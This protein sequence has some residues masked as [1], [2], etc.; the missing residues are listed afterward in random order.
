MTF[1][2]GRQSERGRDLQYLDFARTY[3]EAARRLGEGNGSIETICI[4]FFHLVA[5]ASE[6]ALKAGMSFQ[7]N[8]EE[9]LMWV[10]HALE[11]CRSEA[12]R[13]GFQA[14]EDDRLR[15][16]IS[17]LDRPH[18]MES[19][20]YPQHLHLSLPDATEALNALSE[21]LRVVEA[22]ITNRGIRA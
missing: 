9:N 22:H 8:D 16:F 21:L 17:S 3:G 14:L 7:G 6:L 2:S 15:C 12:A 4:P 10:G 13:G 18:S 1:A 11:S 20:R 19:L 5:H